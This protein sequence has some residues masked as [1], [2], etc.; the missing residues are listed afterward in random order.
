MIMPI[1]KDGEIRITSNLLIEGLRLIGSWDGWV[2]E[3]EMDKIH[4][5][6]INREEMYLLG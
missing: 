2:N 5:S 6:L 4:N 3:I 1:G